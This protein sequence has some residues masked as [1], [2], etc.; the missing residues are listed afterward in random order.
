M[1]VKLYDEFPY[2][3]EFDAN[4]TETGED[5]AGFYVIL[6]KTLF[7][8]EE[9]GQSPDNGTI[10]GEKVL[11]V[12]IR[13]DVIFHYVDCRDFKAGIKVH[14][15]I[16]WEHRFSNM[17]MHS[18]EHIFSGLVHSTFGYN[19]VGFHLSDNSATMDYD[20]KLSDEDVK[21]LEE[22]ANR[23]IYANK[24]ITTYYPSK[25][26]LAGMTYR[27]KKELQGPIRIVIVEDTDVC[28]CCA[29][30]V[31]R[32]GEIGIF[33]IVSAENYKGGT[34]INYLCGIRALRDYCYRT[35][36]LSKISAVLSAKAGEE[37]IE[38]E[39]ASDTIKNL[40]FENLSLKNRLVELAV[41]SEATGKND[42]VRFAGID[43]VP[44]MKFT[45]ETLHKHYPSTCF[46]FA[47][48]E[49]EY[50]Y[51]IESLETDLQPLSQLL[52]DRL[53]AKGGGKKNSIQGSVSAAKADI[54]EVIKSFPGVDL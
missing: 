26:E 47:G 39:K 49:G 29:P 8:P 10:N 40:K 52:R 15:V 37:A 31:K 3:C 5:K 33:K 9:G 41:E 42:G 11:T 18:G 46:L 21:K 4:I 25:E 44:L 22:R 54:L 43:E 2:E 53:S 36:S 48:E 34:R 20:G 13:D 24:S 6:D 12:K 32:T 19:N 16:D 30:H 17:Q 38:V 45:M 14:G 51:L 1:T 35:D 27:L 23:V 50:R 7:F 28:A